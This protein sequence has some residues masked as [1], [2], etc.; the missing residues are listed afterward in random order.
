MQPSQQH[1]G[2]VGASIGGLASATVFHQL[3]FK[4]TVYERSESTFENRGSGLGFVDTALW[5]HL[6]G[7]VMMRRGVEASRQ[8][9][10]FYYGDLWKFLYE[11]LPKGTV[12]HGRNIQSLGEDVD[13]PTIDSEVFDMVVIADGGWS[14]L[15]HC[16]TGPAEP[17]Y[18]GYVG[19]RGCINRKD[20]PWFDAFGIHKNGIFDTIVM[21]QAYDDG[22]DNIVCGA[23]VATPESE[24]L[25]PAAGAS[26][27]GTEDKLL[28]ERHNA[29][30]PHW[31][32]PLYR[33]KFGHMEGGQLARLFETVA[34]KGEV[35]MHP[36]FEF[37]AQQVTN[38][39]VVVVGDAAHMASPRTAVGAHTAVL[40]A[41]ALHEAFAA[42]PAGDVEAALQLYGPDGVERAQ[43]LW[44]RT[45]AVSKDFL[46]RGGKESVLSP[47]TLVNQHQC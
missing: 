35:K 47:A 24:V 26:R 12:K 34:A 41:V 16:V 25:K 33:E 31:F 1:I 43:Q 44:E 18:A 21:P 15:R 36:Q 46:P 23:V 2:I 14:R 11:G 39:R 29:S 28:R 22:T 30:L 3:G 13:R 9:G 6:T 4:V 17:I 7:R 37:G 27:H 42:V 45:R 19:Y 40:D 5:H 20:V 10:A 32:L 38:G 8:Q